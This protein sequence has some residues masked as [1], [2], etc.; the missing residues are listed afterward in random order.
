VHFNNEYSALFSNT[1]ELSIF[2]LFKES[3]YTVYRVNRRERVHI[4]HQGVVYTQSIKC[5]PVP[6]NKYTVK[7]FKP[8]KESEFT[9]DLVQTHNPEAQLL[10]NDEFV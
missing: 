8:K 4:Y 6:N 2:T 9:Y 10:P 7:K 1:I 5:I 3:F